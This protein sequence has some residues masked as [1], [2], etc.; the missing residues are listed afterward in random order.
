[1][2]FEKD[3]VSTKIRDRSPKQFIANISAKMKQLYRDHKRKYMQF[4]GER[5]VKTVKLININ[6]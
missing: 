2:R 3:I 6:K 5:N 4:D 1:M